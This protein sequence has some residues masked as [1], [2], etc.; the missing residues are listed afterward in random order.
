MALPWT[1]R[2]LCSA[3][4]PISHRYSPVLPQRGSADVPLHLASP[5]EQM[6][7]RKLLR[8]AAVA[9]AALTCAPAAAAWAPLRAPAFSLAATYDLFTDIELSSEAVQN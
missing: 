8:A 7:S 9:A 6:P 2:M 3:R 1:R 4:S 5:S